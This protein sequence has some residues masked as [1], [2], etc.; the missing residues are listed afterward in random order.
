MSHLNRKAFAL[1]V[2]E[3]LT[4][5]PLRVAFWGALA[6]AGYRVGV[7][8]RRCWV[9]GRWRRRSAGRRLA[10]P[11]PHPTRGVD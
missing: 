11:I 10:P 6:E 2:D 5:R 3:A 9:V 1:G 7:F 4:L 8:G